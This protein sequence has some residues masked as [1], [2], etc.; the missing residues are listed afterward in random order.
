MFST[1][2]D[3]QQAGYCPRGVFCAFA[4]VDTEMANAREMA[5]GAGGPLDSI[6]DM[7]SGGLPNSS[8]FLI[9][10]FAFLGF[11]FN[12]PLFYFS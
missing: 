6:S 3:V 12:R 11:C 5:A 8:K 2:N 10:F 9:F 4:H 7:L 1:G